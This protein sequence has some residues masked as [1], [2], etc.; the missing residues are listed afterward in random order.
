MGPTVAINTA[1][2]GP[3]LS[4]G[5]MMCVA[6]PILATSTYRRCCLLPPMPCIN[7]YP[8]KWVLL[9][10]AANVMRY[11]VPN[12]SHVANKVASYAAKGTGTTQAWVWAACSQNYQAPQLKRTVNTATCT[13]YIR[14]QSHRCSQPPGPR[15]HL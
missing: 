2:I 13:S 3:I 1:G 4:D 11:N 9:I 14:M 6:Q 7:G 8:D 10:T 15:P 12:A 5:Q